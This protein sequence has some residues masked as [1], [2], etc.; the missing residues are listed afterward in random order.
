LGTILDTLRHSNTVQ[1]LKNFFHNIIRMSNSNSNK[2]YLDKEYLQIVLQLLIKELPIPLYA[3]FHKIMSTTKILI[4]KCEKCSFNTPIITS[5]NILNIDCAQNSIINYFKSTF[6]TQEPFTC[7]QCG[8][9]NNKSTNQR[10]I[11]H[12][13]PDI[14]IVAINRIAITSTPSINGF[15]TTSTYKRLDSKFTFEYNKILDLTEFSFDKQ[16][17]IYTLRGINILKHSL[18]YCSVIK[19]FKANINRWNDTEYK[20]YYCDEETVKVIDEKNIETFFYAKD[21]TGEVA[22]LLFYEKIF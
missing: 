16:K 7:K 18:Q 22:T 21:D 1:S 8:E 5:D 19:S 3:E 4:L 17:V 14:L 13:F 6:V 20:W 9:L 15:P 2:F 10:T 11:Y 12:R